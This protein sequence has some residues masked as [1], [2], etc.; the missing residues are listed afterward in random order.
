MP[1]RAKRFYLCN[2]FPLCEI[3]EKDMDVDT[4][5]NIAILDEKV[6][7]N[8]RRR[9]WAHTLGTTIP[10]ISGV[11]P[12]DFLATWD[13]VAQANLQRRIDLMPGSDVVAFDYRDFRGQKSLFIPDTFVHVD[14]LGDAELVAAA[15][16]TEATET[17]ETA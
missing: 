8:F 12:K 16:V 9:L 2:L 3:D 11:E 7:G 4:E 17:T 6:V 1:T 15:E 10:A 14:T 13:S 5:L